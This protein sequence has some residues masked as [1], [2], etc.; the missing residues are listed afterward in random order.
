MRFLMNLN[1][2]PQTALE[3][4]TDTPPKFNIV[5]I[6]ES[7]QAGRHAKQLS[8]ELLNNI[9]D[10]YQCVRNLWNFDVL[11]IA[12]VGEAAAD[13]ARSADLLIVSASGEHELS[14]HVE[15]WI[16]LWAGLAS[17]ARPAVVALFQNANGRYTD[18]IHLALWA[19]A[20]QAAF[21]YFPHA[22][23][24]PRAALIREERK[25]LAHAA[26][27]QYDEGEWDDGKTVA[28][29]VHFARRIAL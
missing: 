15:K 28:A 12:D 24:Q 23:A 25:H 10:S 29:D 5:I 13:V 14:P 17:G 2:F 22:S 6:Y 8:D 26:G 3:L 16:E 18:K 11:G 1:S 9:G 21:E 7:A 4:L 27:R 19:M 20:E